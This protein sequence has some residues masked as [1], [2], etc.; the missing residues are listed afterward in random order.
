M[1]EEF[2]ERGE[3][4][5]YE[6]RLDR[7]QQLLKTV[8]ADVQVRFH[9]AELRAVEAYLAWEG[10]REAASVSC[11]TLVIHG[12][13]DRAIPVEEG[14]ELAALIPGAAFETFPAS[15]SLLWRH[16][17]ALARA[18]DFIAEADADRTT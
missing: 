1:S 17:P 15:H 14:A 18:L 6:E 7:Q 2:A 4:Q 13:D 12:I 10:Q 3:R 16:E 11:P 5:E 9:S 8:S